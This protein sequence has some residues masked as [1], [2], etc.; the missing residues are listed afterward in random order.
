MPTSCC[1]SVGTRDL[2]D[3]PDNRDGCCSGQL[4]AAPGGAKRGVRLSHRLVPQCIMYIII[5]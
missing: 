4:V 3:N 5:I 2:P 1:P